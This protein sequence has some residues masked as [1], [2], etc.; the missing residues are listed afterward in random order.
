MRHARI[1]LAAV[2]AL[3]TATMFAVPTQAEV[4][5]PSLPI[6][7]QYQLVFLTKEITAA[8]SGDIADYNDFV[9]QQAAISSSLPLATWTAIAS[10]SSFNAIDATSYS[11]PIYDTNGNPLAPNFSTLLS[12]EDFAGP[13]YDQYGDEVLGVVS[14]WTGTKKDGTGHGDSG[15]ELGS[16]APVFGQP[17]DQSWGWLYDGTSANSSSFSLYAISSP[18]TVV[19]EPGTLMLLGTALLSLAAA[20]YLW[21]RRANGYSRYTIPVFRGQV[22]RGHGIPGTGIPRYSGGIPGT[23]VFRGIPVFRG[24]N[25]IYGNIGKVSSGA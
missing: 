19:P 24:H 2:V 17:G 16:L 15:H 9:Q 11:L 22:F 8:E 1:V 21:W 12:D 7:S 13:A 14:V 4:I 25:T 6:G 18:I 5:L 3:A 20:V 10:T 23:Q